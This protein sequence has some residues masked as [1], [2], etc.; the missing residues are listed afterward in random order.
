[1][2]NVNADV[3]EVKRRVREHIVLVVQP[4]NLS[5]VVAAEALLQGHE[6]VQSI[7]RGDNSLRLILKPTVQHYSDLPALLIQSGIALKQFSE[8]EL[9]LEAAFM[10]LTKGTSQRM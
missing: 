5:D 9:D 8:E 7:E 4:E 3:D 2:L 10:A 1:V 6:K